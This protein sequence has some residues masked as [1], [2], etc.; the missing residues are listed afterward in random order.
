MR[1][2]RERVP[3][4]RS[5]HASAHHRHRAPSRQSMSCKQ[6]ANSPQVLALALRSVRRSAL[7][8]AQA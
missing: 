1:A 5:A 3:C 4:G 2:R 8:W 6:S 7:R